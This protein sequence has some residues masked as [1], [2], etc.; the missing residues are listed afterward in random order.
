MSFVLGI[1][2]GPLRES[3]WRFGLKMKLLPEEVFLAFICYSSHG[4]LCLCICLYLQLCLC[5]SVSLCLSPL[6]ITLME[7]ILRLS[8]KPPLPSKDPLCSGISVNY[9]VSV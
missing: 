6:I 3:A 2:L 7:F 8:G 4:Y 9:N 5:L 1:C